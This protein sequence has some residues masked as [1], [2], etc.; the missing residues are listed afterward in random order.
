MGLGLNGKGIPQ[1]LAREGGNV[2]TCARTCRAGS[3]RYRQAQEGD[4]GIP[5][6][7][8]DAGDVQKVV[9]GRIQKFGYLDILVNN[10]SDFE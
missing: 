1:Q 2:T 7:V 5:A 8:T 9:D 6:D 4:T 3:D 10:A